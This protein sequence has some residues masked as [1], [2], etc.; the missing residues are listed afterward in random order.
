MMNS[1]LAI[2][3]FCLFNITC[4][5]GSQPSVWHSLSQIYPV[6]MS[7]ELFIPSFHFFFFV[8]L[9]YKWNSF[10]EKKLCLIQERTGRCIKRAI[11][12]T[13]AKWWRWRRCECRWRKKAFPCRRCERFRC[14]N[15]WRNTNTPTSSGTAVLSFF[16]W[17]LTFN[18][19]F[20][21]FWINQWW[22]CVLM[23]SLMLRGWR[24]LPNL[25]QC[26]QDSTAWKGGYLYTHTHRSPDLH[27]IAIRTCLVWLWCNGE[28]VG[29]SRIVW[30]CLLKLFLFSI[31]SRDSFAFFDGWLLRTEMVAA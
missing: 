8:I 20:F 25:N 15:K 17:W 1:P 16:I 4:P 24:V 14:S 26:R 19:F 13:R 5:T 9:E 3:F 7:I 28:S 30:F 31:K 29:N 21:T 27:T 22:N 23:A 10:I 18:V 6:R 2:N 11:R 12:P